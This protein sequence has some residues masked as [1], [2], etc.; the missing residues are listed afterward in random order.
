[1]TVNFVVHTSRFGQWI[2]SSLVWF[3]G[4]DF[5]SFLFVEFVV[6]SSLRLMATNMAVS[7][8][9]G[10]GWKFMGHFIFKRHF[11]PQISSQS[12]KQGHI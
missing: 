9:R 12:L 3:W 10:D 5:L 8:I 1:M 7:L 11:G 2:F 4:P 6:S